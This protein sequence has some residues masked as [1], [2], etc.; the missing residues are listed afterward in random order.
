MSSSLF[1]SYGDK[2]LFYHCS[3]WLSDLAKPAEELAGCPGLCL[4]SFSTGTQS[5]LLALTRIP[6]TDP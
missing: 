2:Q 5:F 3:D 6:L 1:C 4:S